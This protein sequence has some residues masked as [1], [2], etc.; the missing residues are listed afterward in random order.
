[1]HGGAA[2]SGGQPNNRKAWRHG[3][4]S[5]ETKSERLA[6]RTLLA[7]LRED[8]GRFDVD[9]PVLVGSGGARPRSRTA[10]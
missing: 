2:G 3:E 6:V 9:E 8:L 10:T 7:Y 1:M 5:A 4:Y